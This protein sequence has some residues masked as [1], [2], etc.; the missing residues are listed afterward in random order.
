MHYLAIMAGGAAGVG[1]RMFLSEWSA[2]RFG[3]IL[4]WGTFLANVFGCFLI[5]IISALTGPEG[6]LPAPTLVRQTLMIGVLGGFTTYSSFTL[7]TLNLFNEGQVLHAGLHVV[8]TLF[9]CL[10]A[11]WLGLALANLAGSWFS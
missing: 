6:I 9:L 3:E 5:G 10:F 8:M 4:P 11:T 1:A 7:Q 2:A